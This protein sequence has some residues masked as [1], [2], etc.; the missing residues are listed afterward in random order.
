MDAAA[1]P[2]GA[3]RTAGVAAPWEQLGFATANP[4]QELGGTGVLCPL[5]L[6]LLLDRAPQL[7]AALLAAARG[8]APASE[9]SA[10]QGGGEQ[11]QPPCFPLAEAAVQMAMWV[12]RVLGAGSLGGEAERLGSYFR[13]TGGRG[14]RGG[15][16]QG[17]LSA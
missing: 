4:A 7:A 17:R 1:G 5:L 3:Q 15:P 14:W 11:Q 2:T 8:E 6:L 12:Q 10:A 16:G 13:A 9:C